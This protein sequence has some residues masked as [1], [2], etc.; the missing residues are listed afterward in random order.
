[1]KLMYFGKNFWIEL[2]GYEDF[3]TFYEEIVLEECAFKFIDGTAEEIER[4]FLKMGES[5]GGL[6]D[7]DYYRFD[8]DCDFDEADT[9][10]IFDDLSLFTLDDVIR[11]HEIIANSY[12]QIK[13]RIEEGS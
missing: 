8:C 11:G 6:D 2:H 4:F 1:M 10:F 3:E 7:C 12:R 9:I 13:N 5:C